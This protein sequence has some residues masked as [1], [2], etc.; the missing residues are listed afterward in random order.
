MYLCEQDWQPIAHPGQ[1]GCQIVIEA[2]QIRQFGD[3]FVRDSV[4]AQCVGHGAGC[5]SDDVSIPGIRLRLAWMKISD[6]AHGQSRQVGNGNPQLLDCRENSR[7]YGFRLVHRD[8]QLI[9]LG[10]IRTNHTGPRD[11]TPGTRTTG[12]R[13]HAGTSR[14]PALPFLTES[15]DTSKVAGRAA[16]TSYV[17]KG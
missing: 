1:L 9:M 7:A 11:N 6:A 2:K 17:D 12:A 8:Q 4:P 3:V 15:S 5:I 14:F 13:H 16:F 10:C